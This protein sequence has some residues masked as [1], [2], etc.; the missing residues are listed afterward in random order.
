[1]FVM[2]PVKKLLTLALR[3]GILHHYEGFAGSELNPDGAQLC[4][5][6]QLLHFSE[7][8]VLIIKHRV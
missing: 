1:M 4:D 8:S 3:D 7:S 6:K 2:S 5:L